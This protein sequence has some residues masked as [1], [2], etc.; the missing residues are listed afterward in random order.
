MR[1]DSEVRRDIE[2]EFKWEPRIK[3]DD[4]AVGVRDGIVTLGGFTRSYADSWTA[5]RLA[6]HVRGVKAV[7]NEIEVKLP[8]ASGRSDADIARAAL[9]ALQWH[10]SVPEDRLKVR[11]D[12]GWVTLEGEVDWYYQKE[13]SDH[14][15]RPLMGV[16]GVWNLIVVKARPTP[17]DVKDIIKK[18]M[19][20]SAAFDAE[21]ISVQ[22]HGHKAIL[23]G[24]VRSFTEKRIAERAARNAAGVT[25]VDNQLLV[26]PDIFAVV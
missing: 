1:S 26:E 17:P 10:T 3:D 8:S 11:V 23:R 19:Q 2:Q 12:K 21:R 15:V 14:A 20:R 7:A 25:E 24:S 13:A 16:R 9:N 5:E 4:L 18:A 22:I 6:S